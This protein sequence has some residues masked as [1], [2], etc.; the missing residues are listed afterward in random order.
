LLLKNI[1]GQAK[2]FLFVFLL[3]ESGYKDMLILSVGLIKFLD[4]VNTFRN[5]R[6]S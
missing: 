1:R 5:N 4:K 3:E 2:L 6:A